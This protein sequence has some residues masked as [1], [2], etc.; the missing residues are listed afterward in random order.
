MHDLNKRLDL[1]LLTVFDALMRERHVGRAAERL[2]LTQ[3]A[4][5]HA[6]G[7]LRDLIGD[8][9]F[10]RHARGMRPTPRAEALSATIAPALAALRGS[11]FAQRDFDPSAV[12][13]TVV[14]GSSD[15]IDL[16]LIPYLATQLHRDAPGLDLRFR[17]TSSGTFLEQLRRREIDMAIGPLAVAPQKVELIPLFAERFV[18]VARAGHPAFGR[19]RLS[20]RQF[21]R[22]P[23]LLISPQGDATGP[24]DRALGEMG[25]TRRVAMTVTHFA[26][27]PFVIEATDLVA[28]MPERVAN[29]MRSAADIAIYEL[30]FDL[31]SWTVG[32][33]ALP[34][35][36]ADPLID[37]LVTF[38]RSVAEQRMS[39]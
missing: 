23:Q 21:A 14:I 10:A 36:G 4:V 13:R 6:L 35:G 5:S 1:N 8:P 33:V 15:Y 19:R 25:L 38:I 28:V 39:S 37:W 32:L 30:P 9:L 34:D 27:A 16:V 18:L 17:A 2:A 20:P 24:I 7:R 3:P 26:A 29:R 31:P 12:A 22:L 11:L